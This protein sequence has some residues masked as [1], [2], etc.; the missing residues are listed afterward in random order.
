M[1]KEEIEKYTFFTI[2]GTEKY[3]EFVNDFKNLKE[4]EENLGEDF[5]SDAKDPE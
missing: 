1:T 5:R 2:G 3:E 4:S